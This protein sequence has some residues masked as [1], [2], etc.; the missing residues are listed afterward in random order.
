MNTSTNQSADTKVSDNLV[1][2]MPVLEAP[3]PIGKPVYQVLAS[4][5]DARLRCLK[6]G[7]EW[8]DKHEENILAICKNEL[9]S[10]SGINCGTKIDL[11]KSTGDKLVFNMSFHHM[12]DGG[13]YDGWTEH[14]VTVKP[15]L[16]FDIEL[17]ISGRDRNQIKEYLY[18]TYRLA[19][20]EPCETY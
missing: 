18:E 15:S 12:N 10:G 2:S 8:A 16:Q 5:V 7:N 4:L 11:D 19:L 6:T 20:T 9:P 3:K 14:V 13:Y 17:S 1:G